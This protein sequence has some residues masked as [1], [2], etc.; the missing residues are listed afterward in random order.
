MPPIP[1][2]EYPPPV[3]RSSPGD[4]PEQP[5]ERT[6]KPEMP[7]S[8]TKSHKPFIERVAPEQPRQAVVM[9]HPETVT[10]PPVQDV[11]RQ[12]EPSKRS[13]P[14]PSKSL[15]PVKAKA[16]E[17]KTSTSG[18]KPV[19]KDTAPEEKASGSGKKKKDDTY[20]GKLG[21][22]HTELQIEEILDFYLQTGLLPTY[23]SQKMRWLYKHHRRLPERREL[24][25]QAGTKIVVPEVERD[26][27]NITPIKRTNVH[28]NGVS[29]KSV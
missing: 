14:E 5:K 1:P 2:Y 9:S 21:R 3:A 27:N 28:G 7:V 22:K 8:P 20:D 17:A 10:L 16:P 13:T 11:V 6:N 29:R 19:E 18:H 25:E 24:L 23:V 4:S 15:T 12:P 26:V